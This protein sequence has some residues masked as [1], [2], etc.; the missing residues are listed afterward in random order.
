[1]S[2]KGLP[3]VR[4][5]SALRGGYWGAFNDISA[6]VKVKTRPAACQR[7]TVP[8]GKALGRLLWFP[9]KPHAGNVLVTQSRSGPRWGSEEKA[10][11]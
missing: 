8:G 7:T 3:R 1:M 2:F 10:S 11:Y 9:S 6:S 5:K 4:T